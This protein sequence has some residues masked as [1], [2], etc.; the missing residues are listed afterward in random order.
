MP[1]LDDIIFTVQGD[2]L[3]FKASDGE[4]TMLADMTLVSTDGEGC[5]A[6][7]GRNIM[8]AIKNLPE[9]PLTFT[10]NEE[11]ATVQVDYFSGIFTLPT[12]NPSEFPVMPDMNA[13]ETIAFNI[14]EEVLQENIARSIFATADDDIRPVMGGIFFDLTT[15]YLAVVATNGHQLIRNRVF[16]VKGSDET[17]TG[18]FIMPKKV[19]NILKNMLR[20]GI[21]DEITVTFDGRQAVIQTKNF[22]LQTR[23]IEGRYPNYNSVIP[24]NNPNIAKVDRNMLIAALKR[25]APFANNS[26]KLVKLTIEGEKMQLDT[27]DYDFSKTATEYMTC[28]YNGTDI[29]IGLKSNNTLEILCNMSCEDISIQMAD[30]SRAIVILPIEQPAMQEIIM[31]QMP[32][33]ID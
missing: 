9:I 31:L 23:L 2:T 26:S 30:P 18:N 17:K 6:V 7:N 21:E 1:I 8:E 32:M 16:S 29:A 24:R 12:D 19:A 22:S 15:E 5:F 11:K 3:A 25:V 13:D 28:D 33:L 14:S 4:V 10:Y 20:K 27:E